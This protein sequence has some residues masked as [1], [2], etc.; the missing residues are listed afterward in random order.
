MV[1]TKA[2]KRV[3][4]WDATKVVPKAETKAETKEPC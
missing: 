4:R 3:A 1:L 2:A